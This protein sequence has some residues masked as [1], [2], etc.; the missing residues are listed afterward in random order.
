MWCLSLAPLASARLWHNHRHGTAAAAAARAPSVWEE[1]EGSDE[2]DEE[3]EEGR[4]EGSGGEEAEVVAVACNDGCVR[5]FV[6]S[7]S[8]GGGL[9]YMQ[10]LPRVNG[11]APGRTDTWGPHARS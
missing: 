6:P 1:G 4:E 10:S 7:G 5:L 8:S 11:K 3:D 2:E 9:E